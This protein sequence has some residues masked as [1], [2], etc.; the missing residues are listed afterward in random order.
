MRHSFGTHRAKARVIHDCIW[1]GEAIS[2]GYIAVVHEWRDDDFGFMRDYWHPSCE[3]VQRNSDIDEF[4][5]H[6]Q[7]RGEYDPDRA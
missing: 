6:S 5:P 2:L 4:E 1:C 7:L 3:E